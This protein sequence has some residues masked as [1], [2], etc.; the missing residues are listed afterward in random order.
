M[1]F[2]NIFLIVKWIQRT[3]IS[4]LI[5]INIAESCPKGMLS[6]RAI[7]EERAGVSDPSAGG[8]EM[9]K[10]LFLITNTLTGTNSA[11]GLLILRVGIVFTMAYLHGFP[12]L[13][14]YSQMSGSF[15]DP[16][17]LGSGISMAL[18]I[19]AEFFCSLALALGLFTRLA[20]IPLITTMGVAFFMFHASDPLSKKELPLI[21][22]G[23]LCLFPVCRGREIF[24]GL[25]DRQENQAVDFI[26]VSSDFKVYGIAVS[27]FHGKSA[28]PVCGN[29]YQELYYYSMR[30]FPYGCKIIL[31]EIPWG[32]VKCL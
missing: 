28:I 32:G 14:G 17:G 30:L 31:A 20:S 5:Q 11:I 29:S 9:K 1:P 4:Y 21:Y 25:P 23:Y 3:R 7:F 26:H 2:T 10:P 27:D 8:Y 18:V 6:Q 12:K 13:T 19:F 16:L 24:S 22:P 15:P